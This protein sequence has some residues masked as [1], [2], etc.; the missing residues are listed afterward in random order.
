MAVLE[1]R[2][3]NKEKFLAILRSFYSM[4]KLSSLEESKPISTGRSASV[5][6]HRENELSKVR[7]RGVVQ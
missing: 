1:R 6:K 7:E 2:C 4:E 3:S 5:P